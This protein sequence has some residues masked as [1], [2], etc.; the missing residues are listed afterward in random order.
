[1]HHVR[2]TNLLHAVA[3]SSPRLLRRLQLAAQGHLTL[4]L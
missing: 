2:D 4:L 1:M 3:Q